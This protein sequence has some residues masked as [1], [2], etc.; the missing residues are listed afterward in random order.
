MILGEIEVNVLNLCGQKL[1]NTLKQFVCNLRTNYLSLFRH[2]V[3]W[4]LKEL[5]VKF[6]EQPA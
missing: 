6:G 3:R 4:H 5:E 2:S 1:T